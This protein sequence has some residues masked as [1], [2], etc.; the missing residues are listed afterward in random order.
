MFKVTT[1]DSTN[2]ITLKMQRN[3]K[4]F[5]EISNLYTVRQYYSLFWTH[6][7]LK[8]HMY[9]LSEVQSAIHR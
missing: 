3:P 6:L 4:N 8:L 2:Q 7:S 5:Y 1:A 9:T